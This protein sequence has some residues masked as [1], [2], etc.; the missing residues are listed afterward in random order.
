MIDEKIIET[1]ELDDGWSLAVADFFGRFRL[2]LEK[3][4]D[5]KLQHMYASPRFTTL[6]GAM[7]YLPIARL[8]ANEECARGNTITEDTRTLNYTG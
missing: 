3:R 2:Y 7:L 6:E 5:G 1:R 8:T 4:N